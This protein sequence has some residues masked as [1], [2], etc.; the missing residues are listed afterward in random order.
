MNKIIEK[1]RLS[2]FKKFLKYPLWTVK[3]SILSRILHNFLR[4]KVAINS[5]VKLFFDEE[6]YLT[7][8]PNYGIKFYNAYVEEDCEVRATKF[9][10]KNLSKGD[11][12]FD[13]GANQGYYS[14][15][16]SKL[17]GDSGKVVAFEPD[18]NVFK[19][20][21]KNKRDN[22][23]ILNY[24][25]SDENGPV[26]LYSFSSLSTLSTLVKT[27]SAMVAE[28]RKFKPVRFTVKSITLDSFCSNFKLIPT[29]M[30]VD[31][32]GAEFLVLKGAETILKKYDPIIIL[33]TWVDNFDTFHK[34]VLEFA[35]KL[36]YRTYIINEDGAIEFARDLTKYFE[37]LLNRYKII[38][39]KLYT[40]N[41]VFMKS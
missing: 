12:F 27:Y 25:V 39:E 32:E 29:F 41:L 2:K 17:V 35:I 33:E 37:K 36:G 13:I 1:F 16:S 34:D 3:V 22:M 14:I 4:D 24:A 8:P 26:E 31:V 23:T 11:I 28:E 7:Y 30:K 40:D 6:M 21:Q 10:I 38:G 20:L 5:K 19:I 9:L 15:L 18:P